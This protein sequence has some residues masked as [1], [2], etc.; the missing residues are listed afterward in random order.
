VEDYIHTLTH[1]QSYFLKKKRFSFFSYSFVNHLCRAKEYVVKCN[2]ERK[3][4]TEE[5]PES[6]HSADCCNWCCSEELVKALALSSRLGN[7]EVVSFVFCHIS[8]VFNLADGL[9]P[10][11]WEKRKSL[12]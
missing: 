3:W 2:L 8:L 9:K 1:I 10:S 7:V 12:S 11:P 6:F 5:G 4:S